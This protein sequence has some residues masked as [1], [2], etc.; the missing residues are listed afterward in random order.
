DPTTSKV[1]SLMKVAPP[2]AVDF[3]FSKIAKLMIESEMRQL[4]VFEKNKLLGFVTD[5]DII[6]AAVLQ[7]WGNTAID[8][9]MTRAP[10]TIEANRSVGAV[11]SL[12]R[13]CGI[14]HV[15]VTDNGKL[16][17]MIS[18]QDILQNI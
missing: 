8:K 12:M 14:S 9:I 17:G 2:V 11:L 3:S 1:K 4:P 16:T 6:H 7:E 18:I 5:D 15:P 13:E 10:H